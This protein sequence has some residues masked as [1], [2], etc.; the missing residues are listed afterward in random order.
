MNRERQ[1]S[2]RAMLVGSA[3][4]VG[5][6]ALALAGASVMGGR[7]FL[8]R[9][10]LAQDDAPAGFGPTNRH[11]T[12]ETQIAS[13]TVGQLGHA[14]TVSAE[15]HVSH[16][17]LIDPGSNRLYFADWG[18][19]VYAADATTGE[20][21]WQKQVQETVM[22]KWPWYGFAGSG[23]LGEGMLFEASV[24]GTAYAIDQ[25][26]GEVIWQTEFTDD[27]EAGNVGKLLY[28]D[29][30][31]YI[32]VQ[33]VEEPLTRMMPDFQPNFRGKV[34]AL[35]AK[36]GGMVWELVLVEEGANGVPVWSGFALD[37]ETNTLFFGTGNNYTPPAT[38]LSD[39]LVAV[40]AKTGEFRWARQA[41]PRDIWTPVQP[42]GPDFDFGAAPQL[43][44]ATINGEERRLVGIGQKSGIFWVFDRQTGDAIWHTEVG[45][46]GVGG[47]IHA[48]AAVGETAIYVW[49]N[50]S[51]AYGKPPEQ[52]PL[53]VKA[54]DQATGENLWVIPQ[55]QPA[56]I[57]AAAFLANDAV[58]VG[59][60]DG[61][62]RAYRTSDGGQLWR[63]QSHGAVGGAIV[64][65][66]DYLYFPAGIPKMFGGGTGQNGIVAYALGAPT[67]TP[68]GTP[69]GVGTQI[70]GPGGA[71][72]I[73]VETPEGG[74]GMVPGVGEGTV[75]PGEAEAT[76]G[77]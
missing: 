62:V 1:L 56:A 25:K 29:G 28:H 63:S 73:V 46:G 33:S 31:V 49:S 74:G 54:L 76:P 48:E 55:A 7:S 24:E 9:P 47:G 77:A 32:G 71:T 10:A 35:D 70:P 51:Y 72:P 13:D 57:P 5:G 21:A 4:V 26:T 6:G 17:P 16:W 14:W 50:N 67:G 59:S 23:T 44:E 19:T 52:F 68:Q 42:I 65:V 75:V 3:R 61:I 45:Y 41:T 12:T 11:S 58:F 40:D 37:P 15:E 2:R 69:F 18:G 43:F 66:G 39:S 53:T 64:A 20:L 38:S 22:S 27:P 30:L 8:P 60:L 34:V 36:T